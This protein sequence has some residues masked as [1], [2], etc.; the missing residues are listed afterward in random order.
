VRVDRAGLAAQRSTLVA[1]DR[2]TGEPLAPAIS[3]QDRRAANLL[4]PYADRAAAI[5]AIT[6]LPLS[7]HYLAGKI[8]WL[9]AEDDA[10]QSARQNGR[11]RVGP[12]A[13]FLCANLLRGQP[14]LVDHSNAARSLL[15][16]LRRLDWSNELLALFDIPRSILPDCRPTLA[17]YGPLIGHDIEL[18]CVCGDQNAAIH[19]DGIPAADTA[20]INIGSGAFVLRSSGSL[21]PDHPRL[22][23]GI[24]LSRND[25]AD[26]LLEGTVNGAGSAVDAMRKRETEADY[27]RLLSQWL[28]EFR[29]PPICINSIGGLGSP[30]WVDQAPMRFIPEDSDRA[31]Q[32]VAVME[33][34]L[35][36]LLDNLAEMAPESIQRLRISGGL[37]RL[38]GLCQRLADLTGIPV[39][40][41]ADHEA[42]ARG[43]AWLAHGP[44]RPWPQAQKPELFTPRA[45]PALKRRYRHYRH[46]LLTLLGAQ[47]DWRRRADAAARR[48]KTPRIVAHRGYRGRHRENTLTAIAAAIAGGADAVE[49]DI[50]FSRDGEPMIFHDETLARMTGE[51]GRIFDYNRGQLENIPILPAAG[52]TATERIPNLDQVIEVMAAHPRVLFF[53]EVKRHTL[54]H[55]GTERVMRRLLADLRGAGSHCIIISFE[56]GCL[57]YTRRNSDLAIGWVLREYDAAHRAAAELLLPDYLIVNHEKLSGEPPWP[58]PWDWMVYEINDRESAERYYRLGADYISTAEVAGLVTK[59]DKES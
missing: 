31:G 41:T 12:L 13:S 51:P 24:A 45:N 14:F 58:G 57:E 18:H 49:F 17:K 39:S 1:W 42:T 11:L 28:E 22:L 21:P 2:E 43:V 35:F 10:V 9:L 37:S 4:Q 53:A 50:Q 33:G 27:R 15:F 54:G 36:M 59:Q 32:T 3:W 38:D 20:L 19:A 34:I 6:G 55:F 5:H 44:T 40:R 52:D 29:E 48:K 25:H 56:R 47:A 8:K 46:A 16:D 30:W 26:Y 23:G 7:P